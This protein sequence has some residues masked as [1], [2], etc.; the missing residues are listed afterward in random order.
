LPAARERLLRRADPARADFA[1]ALRL[2]VAFF[3]RRVFVAAARPA[4][5]R[6]RREDFFRAAMDPSLPQRPQ[7]SRAR[8]GFYAAPE[9]GV[10]A[11]LDRA[12]SRQGRAGFGASLLAC[13]SS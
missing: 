9:S 6:R 3:L 5:F 4:G 11:Q 12:G 13:V 1:D 8:L 2:R 10:N 7:R